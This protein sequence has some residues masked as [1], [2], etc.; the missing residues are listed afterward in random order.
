MAS[1][2]NTACISNIVIPA[3]AA[4]QVSDDGGLGP[5]IRRDDVQIVLCGTVRR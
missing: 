5:G 2:E 1:P 3:N 4:T